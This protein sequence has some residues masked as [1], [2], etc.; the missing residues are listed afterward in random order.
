MRLFYFKEK[1]TNSMCH[2]G[3]TM[4]KHMFQWKNLFIK[5]FLL[6]FGFY[7]IKASVMKELSGNY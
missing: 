1:P 4:N 6:N 3:K 2:G 5:I 7:M